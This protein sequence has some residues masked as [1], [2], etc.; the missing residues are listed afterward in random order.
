M[1]HVARRAGIRGGFVVFHYLRLGAERWN[2]D[3]LG[4]RPGPHWHVVGDGWLRAIAP[5][6]RNP[7]EGWLVKNLR[8][9]RDVDGTIH[10]LL[11]HAALP[12]R[13]AVPAA[14]IL[15]SGNLRSTRAPVEALTWFGTFAYNRLRVP[16]EE[17]E[18]VKCGVCGAED[19]EWSLELEWVGQGPPPARE[20]FV[21]R[22][23][24][25]RAYALDRTE[26]Y[27]RSE[28]VEVRA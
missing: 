19:H 15:P 10:Y 8:V 14:G 18:R 16:P 25:W 13:E 5:G 23:E 2:G 24:D 22:A 11:T 7:H 28:R 6:E 3:E 9:R 4:C 27:G 21:A 12:V 20:W 17:P 1:Y 26:G